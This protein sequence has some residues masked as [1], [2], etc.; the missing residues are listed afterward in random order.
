MATLPGNLA[1]VAQLD[2]FEPRAFGP[3]RQAESRAELLDAFTASLADARH[4]LMGMSDR[5][6]REAWTLARAGQPDL[7]MS[8]ERMLRGILLNHWSHHRGQ[9]T[10]YLRLLDVPLP[11]I[12]GA[13]ADEELA[14]DDEAIGVE[15]FDVSVPA[16]AA[17]PRRA[18]K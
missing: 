3:Q 9:L 6:A 4:L 14:A 16:S 5:F 12:Y 8:R 7:V 13:T 2:V 17:P 10:A 15:P 1:R 18:G 11:A